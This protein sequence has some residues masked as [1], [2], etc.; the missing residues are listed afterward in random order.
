MTGPPLRRLRRRLGGQI[1][2]GAELHVGAQGMTGR[3]RKRVTGQVRWSLVMMSF[4]S[5][6]WS[7]APAAGCQGED[8]GS[9][10]LSRDPLM[11]HPGLTAVGSYR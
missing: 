1:R 3:S 6:S 2:T 5:S 9:S 8:I 7:G 11:A 10:P 4:T